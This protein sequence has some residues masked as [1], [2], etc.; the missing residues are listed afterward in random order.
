[1]SKKY[2]AYWIHLLEHSDIMNEG[3]VGISNNTKRRFKE[4]SKSKNSIISNAIQKYGSEL[5]W[6]V[7]F[8]NLSYDEAIKIERN[9]RPNMRIGWNIMTGGNIPPSFEGMERPSHSERMKGKN[10][11]FH[12]KTHSDD[13]KLLLSEGMRGENNPFYGKKGQIIQKR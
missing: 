11:P 5:L 2:S 8:E 4:H 12:G 13:V 10:N 1:M 7:V 3:Y 6:D 9:L